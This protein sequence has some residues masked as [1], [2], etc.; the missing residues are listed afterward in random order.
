DL[1]ALD[2]AVLEQ[3]GELFTRSPGRCRVAFDLIQDDGTEAT[4]ESS[5]AVRADR[6]LVERVR[7][8]FGSD[9]VALVQCT[10]SVTKREKLRE[11]LRRRRERK[12]ALKAA[13]LAERAAH[14]D[15]N[16]YG[17]DNVVTA[18]PAAQTPREKEPQ[19]ARAITALERDVEELGRL[20]PTEEGN[21]EIE[22]LRREVEELRREFFANISAWQRLQLARHPQRPYRDDFIRLR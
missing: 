1:K 12:K 4:L 13:K 16:N 11:R 15:D 3:L 2:P 5:S 8:I 22:R 9:S 21:A 19:R 17:E 20:S 10:G 14:S 7:E 18:D 6:E